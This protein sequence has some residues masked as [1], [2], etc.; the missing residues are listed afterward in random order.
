MGARLVRDRIGDVPWKVEEAKVGLRRVT[1]QKE[2]FALLR[3][4]LLEEIGEFLIADNEDDTITEAADV[5]Q[6]MIDMIRLRGF[7]GDDEAGVAKINLDAVITVRR[8]AKAKA[9]GGFEYG[10]VWEV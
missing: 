7:S 4:K 10:T 3:S 6:V 5:L 2:H 8:L 9:L 1:S